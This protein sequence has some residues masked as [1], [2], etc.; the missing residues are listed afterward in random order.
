MPKKYMPKKY[1]PKKYN[2]NIIIIS[3]KYNN[4]KE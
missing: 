1:M 2:L 4:G 3:I